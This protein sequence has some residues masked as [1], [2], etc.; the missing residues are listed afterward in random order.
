MEL[1]RSA[2]SFSGFRKSK[3]DMLI[4][5]LRHIQRRK[6][7]RNVRRGV[8][9]AERI[10][11]S[12]WHGASRERLHGAV[13]AVARRRFTPRHARVDGFGAVAHVAQLHARDAKRGGLFY[14]AA[15]VRHDAE[16]V[17][18]HARRLA[19]MHGLRY[20]QIAR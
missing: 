5:Y 1:A 16:G 15:R 20:Y 18:Q 8:R 3:M 19:I 10:G 12:P 14:Q 2:M 11:G 17:R 13:N 6:M 4:I 7:S 9:A